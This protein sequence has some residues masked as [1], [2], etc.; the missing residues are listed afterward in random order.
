MSA[1]NIRTCEYW[2][3]YSHKLILI[4]ICAQANIDDAIA[5]T[6]KRDVLVKYTFWWHIRV[7]IYVLVQHKWVT[8][9][10][11]SHSLS[12]PRLNKNYKFPTYTLEWRRSNV[13]IIYA[14]IWRRD[15]WVRTFGLQDGMTDERTF[16]RP[17]S[18]YLVFLFEKNTTK[19]N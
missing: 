1:N 14:F 2:L 12:Q 6:R 3:Q 18:Q 16:F 8:Y 9:E 13:M 11:N 10:L 7:H 5:Y 15:V 19:T 17:N 4:A